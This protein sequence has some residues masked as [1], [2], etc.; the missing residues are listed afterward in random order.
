MNQSALGRV[1][2]TLLVYAGVSWL[3]LGLSGW[4][5]R[6]LA[7]PGLFDALV[8]WGLVLGAALAVLVAWQY[9]AIVAGQDQRARP[10]PPG[11]GP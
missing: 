11:A 7:L 4:L 6:V 3:V 10:R 9:P 1:I 8:F 2:L 5:R